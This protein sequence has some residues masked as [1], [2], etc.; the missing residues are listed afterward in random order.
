VRNSV[1]HGIEPS[2]VRVKNGKSAE[3]TLWLR[4]YHEGGQVIIE[5]ADDG[6]GISLDRV[7]QKA[8]EKGMVTAE[9]AAAM[10]DRESIQLIL[11]PGFST[12]AKVTNVSGRGVGMDVVKT[13]V[14]K[15]GGTLD[16]QSRLGQGT[17]LRIKIPLTLAIIPALI[18]T[19]A[20]D[21]YAIP[22]VSLL[23]LVRLEGEQV[24]TSIEYV[25]GAP[26]YRLRGK[27]LPLVDLSERLGVV[28]ANSDARQSFE[29]RII[30][31]VVLRANDRQYGLVVD[32]VN[33]TAE[34]VVKPLSRQLKG[35]AE[36]AGTTIMG[37]GSVALILDV[38]GIA[39]AAGLTGDLRDQAHASAGRD[40]SQTAEPTQTLLVVDLGDARRFALPTSMV[41][42]LEKVPGSAIEYT[43]GREVIQYRGAIL[44]VVRLQHVFGG[45]SADSAESDEL[46]LIVYAEEDHHCGFAVNRIVDIV[47][48]ELRL[49]T[50]N[51]DHD[52]L[53]GTTVIQQ[54]V[55]DVL[56][57]RNL[58]RHG[59]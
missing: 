24:R 54:R 15:I 45:G 44:P 57:L 21:R 58:A 33:D 51:G 46:Q 31:I 22:Q 55:T 19:T 34:I 11:L 50:K 47:E 2:D 53:L 30:N 36:Y 4:A 13:N 52:N 17:T 6:G 29:D 9:Q 40:S 49:Q 32:K 42:R 39:I 5:I 59:A 7:R 43:D 41:A 1:D 16:I 48:T 37:D 12:A 14:E 18:V 38:M 25:H 26:V 56:N 23:E 35:I 8:I 10:S 3:G 20:G 27:L 28:P